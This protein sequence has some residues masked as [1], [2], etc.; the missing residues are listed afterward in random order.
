[1]F[2]ILTSKKS[3]AYLLTFKIVCNCVPLIRLSPADMDN[4]NNNNNNYNNDNQLLRK[5]VSRPRQK[6]AAQIIGVAGKTYGLQLPK[7]SEPSTERCLRIFEEEDDDNSN[8][9]E[10]STTAVATGA[11]S[12]RQPLTTVAHK[13]P[14]SEDAA[15]ERALSGVRTVTAGGEEQDL[16]AWSA[17]VAAAANAEKLRRESKAAQ[18]RVLAE[19]PSAYEY[20]SI[21]DDMHRGRAQAEELKAA[22]NAQRMPKYMLGMQRKAERR[23]HFLDV[24]HVKKLQREAEKERAIYGDKEVFIS[25]SYRRK[26]AESKLWEDEDNAGV[27]EGGNANNSEFYSN[28]IRESVDAR[29]AYGAEL[30]E[31]ALLIK[32]LREERQ[33]RQQEQQLPAEKRQKTSETDAHDKHNSD[34]NGG[35]SDSRSSSNNNNEYEKRRVE[36]EEEEEEIERRERREEAARRAARR[37]EVERGFFEAQNAEKAEAAQRKAEFEARLARR[38]TQDSI[39]SAKERYLERKQKLAADLKAAREKADAN[40]DK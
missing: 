28:L 35:S 38:N 30:N 15:S 21:Y 31:D 11:T 36:I 16:A 37:K 19:D 27:D 33:Q 10:E 22:D 13:R 8:N 34:D 1:M 12:K 32:K 25:E 40:A 39:K 20:D 24:A 3:R 23:K 6:V 9:N 17:S 26:L 5:R 18:A 29:K 2:L 4:N 7:N 14:L